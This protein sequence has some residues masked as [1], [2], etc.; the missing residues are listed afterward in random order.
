MSGKLRAEVLQTHT[1]SSFNGRSGFG[2]TSGDTYHAE[3]GHFGGNL[4]AHPANSTRNT[5]KSAGMPEAWQGG[6]VRTD[7]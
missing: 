7:V 3:P 1:P 2:A 6:V 5:A 4:P